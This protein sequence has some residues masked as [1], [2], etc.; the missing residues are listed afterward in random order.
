M[1]PGTPISD[2]PPA[3][4]NFP[5]LSDYMGHWY[6]EPALDLKNINNSYAETVAGLYYMWATLKYL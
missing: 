6:W 2:D 1:V 5:S 3:Q 4:E